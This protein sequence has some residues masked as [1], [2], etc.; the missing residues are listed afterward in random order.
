MNA[1]SKQCTD[2]VKNLKSSA[3]CFVCSA[4]NYE[5]FVKEKAII[6]RPTCSLVLESCMRHF[7]TLD[8]IH[9][10]TAKILTKRSTF[11]K[12]RGFNSKMQD[13]YQRSDFS[14]F[15]RNIRRV[16]KGDNSIDATKNICKLVYTITKKSVVDD[17]VK[18]L[19]CAADLTLRY[20]QK[21][22]LGR[23]WIDCMIIP[24]RQFGHIGSGGMLEDPPSDDFSSV[25]FIEDTDKLE[26]RPTPGPL[27]R[28]PS[29]FQFSKMSTCHNPTRHK[30][31]NLSM[32][33]P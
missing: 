21:K 15:L 29:N 18:F 11:E 22:K 14:E 20:V 30:P 4:N 12:E 9:Q 33:F 10:F 26:S 19:H 1:D 2:H 28:R 17:L 25:A 13:A 6:T 31:M 8:K 5:Y 7:I 24:K 3:L 27:L 32:H 23:D 16:E